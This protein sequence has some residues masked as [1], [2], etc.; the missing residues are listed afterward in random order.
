MVKLFKILTL[1]R[2]L[3]KTL[4]PSLVT[5]LTFSVGTFTS[6]HSFAGPGFFQAPQGIEETWA[7]NATY[8]LVDAGGSM[9]NYTSGVAVAKTKTNQKTLIAYLTSFHSIRSFIKNS[10]NREIKMLGQFEF[11]TILSIKEEVPGA[12]KIEAIFPKIE[13]DLALVIVSAPLASYES[14]EILGFPDNCLNQLGEWVGTVGFPLLV[15]TNFQ[16]I[17]DPGR[18]QSRISKQFSRGKVTEVDLTTKSGY[19]QNLSGTSADSRLGN[20][21]GPAFNE[22][23]FL[24]GIVIGSRNL[25]DEGYVGSDGGSTPPKSHSVI[26]Q[27]A[28]TKEFALGTWRGYLSRKLMG[29]GPPEIAY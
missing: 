10:R 8:A 18:P 1:F 19:S 4:W 17:L 3:T 23:G 16:I 29:Q 12:I 20:S 24:V 15:Q 9:L 28:V 11:Q 7:W 21:G 5:A 25:N 2:V 13:V 14:I 27:C 26:T 22:Q 6:F